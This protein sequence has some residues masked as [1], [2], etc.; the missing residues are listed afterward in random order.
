MWGLVQVGDWIQGCYFYVHF[1]WIRR[2]CGAKT[3]CQFSF[4]LGMCWKFN[5]YDLWKKS[6][7]WKWVAQY[8]ITCTQWCSC[9]ST[10]GRT[11]NLSRHMGRK[12]WQSALIPLSLVMHGPNIFG[13]TIANL[14]HMSI[15]FKYFFSFLVQDGI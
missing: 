6:R 8:L 14:V 11:L 12:R 5:A 15:T 2:L 4:E 10:I 7:M 1:M 13:L 3:M 9:P